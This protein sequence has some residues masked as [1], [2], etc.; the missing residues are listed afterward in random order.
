MSPTF[1]HAGIAGV[2]TGLA[3]A[4]EFTFFL[5]SGYSPD[6]FSSVAAALTYLQQHGDVFLRIGGLFGA[7]G[8]VI[9]VIYVAGLAAKLR[10]KTPTQA[11]ATLYF[12]VLGAIGH[13]LV[14]LSFYVGMPML[15]A[16]AAQDQAAATAVLSAFTI[17]TN[18]FQALGNGLLGLV[19]LGTGWAIIA[20]RA[21]PV[22]VGWVGVFAG[23]ATLL[24]VLTGGTPLAAVGFVVYIPSLLLA[25]VFDI[26]AGFAIWKGT[27]DAGAIG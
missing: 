5:L 15:L 9:R 20:R 16:L 13:G 14:A 2:L 7:A 23:I 26:W 18:G 11:V 12:G 19:L 6:S 3:L 1:K 25:I 27:G 17:I 22:G 21:L 8:A 24:G 10:A 4:V